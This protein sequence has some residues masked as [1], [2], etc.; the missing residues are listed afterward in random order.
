MPELE[1]IGDQEILEAFLRGDQSIDG[2]LLDRLWP[3]VVG[4]ARK[5]AADLGRNQYSRGM[6]LDPEE[7]TNQTLAEFMEMMAKTSSSSCSFTWIHLIRWLRRRV[8]YRILDQNR[9]WHTQRR[10]GGQIKS[11]EDVIGWIDEEGETISYDPPSSS[12]D[13]PE[14]F[15]KLHQCLDRLK[16]S[17]KELFNK[18]HLDETTQANLALE[19]KMPQGTLAVRLMRITG[20]LRDCLK[21]GGITG[22]GRFT[23]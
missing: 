4:C 7:A 9:R 19:Y 1:E 15:Y 2:P 3:Q 21:R 6:N 18:K 12:G 22:Y 20:R 16:P 5:V 11:F 14:S 8:T 17:E 10:L 23:L 13:E